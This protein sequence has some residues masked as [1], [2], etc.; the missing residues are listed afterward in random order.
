MKDSLKADLRRCSDT[1]KRGGG[2]PEAQHTSSGR[3]WCVQGNR[4]EEKKADEEEGEAKDGPWFNASVVLSLSS[5]WDKTR[6]LC[7]FC[8]G[9]LNKMLKPVGFQANSSLFFC[10]LTYI[11]HLFWAELHFKVLSLLP[12]CLSRVLSVECSAAQGCRC[13]YRLFYLSYNLQVFFFLF[14]I[15]LTTFVF[16]M[17]RDIK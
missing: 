16:F 5:D 6:F 14:Q 3:G 10:V 13:A 7:A 15:S 1:G 17:Q 11:I 4:P 8:Q 9:F 12:P 2:V